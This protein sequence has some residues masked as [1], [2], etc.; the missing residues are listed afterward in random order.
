MNEIHDRRKEIPEHP[1]IADMER[2]GYV[3]AANGWLCKMAWRYGGE[4]WKEESNLRSTE[5]TM[6]R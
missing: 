2:F 3:R 6:R 1:V 5:A 4:Q